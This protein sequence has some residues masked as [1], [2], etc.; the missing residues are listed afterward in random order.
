MSAWVT[1]SWLVQVPYS[2]SCPRLCSLCLT[3]LT[4][5]ILHLDFAIDRPG[6]FLVVVVLC[7]GRGS[8]FGRVIWSN[9]QVEHDN[10]KICNPVK[11]EVVKAT[12]FILSSLTHGGSHCSLCT[13]LQFIKVILH[14][15]SSSSSVFKG[16]FLVAVAD[17]VW[18]IPQFNSSPQSLF[19]PP[20]REL[21]SLCPHA[22]R[23]RRYSI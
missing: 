6:R 4:A 5:T 22:P 1:G 2:T 9:I 14:G 18:S 3:S 17:G 23:P 11:K 15:L 20:S 19:H 13:T 21:H 8:Y 12:G 16:S 7:R 10:T